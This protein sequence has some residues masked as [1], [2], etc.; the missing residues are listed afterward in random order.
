MKKPAFRLCHYAK[1]SQV[2][3]DAGVFAVYSYPW[4]PEIDTPELVNSMTSKSINNHLHCLH[5]IFPWVG[6]SV[7]LRMG[8]L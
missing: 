5:L 3:D 8:Q 7:C 1:T 4:A 6:Q 2:V